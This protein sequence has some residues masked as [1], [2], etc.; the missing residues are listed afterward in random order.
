MTETEQLAAFVADFELKRLPGEVVHQ[1]KRCLLETIGCALGGAR[2]PLAATALGAAR[3]L[4]EGGCATVLGQGFRTAPDR[5]AFLNG[6]AGNALD[7]D[8]GIVRQGHYGPTVVASALAVGELVQAPGER[9]LAAVVAGYE[10][11]ARV[12]MA[13]R[14][15]PGQ[16]ALVSGYG[17]YQGFGAVAAAGLLLGLDRDRMVH[18][19]GLCGAF[20]PVPSTKGC[21][22]DRRPLSWTKDMVAWPSVSGINAALLAEAGFLGPR[23]IFEGDR[24]FFRM[25]GSDRCAPDQLVAGLGREFRILDLYFKPYPCCRWIHA[26]LEGVREILRRRGWAGTEVRAVRVGVAQ[27]VLDDLADPSPRNLVDAEFSLPYG[28]AMVLL[29]REPGPRWHDPALLTD[30]QVTAAM[31]KVAVVQDAGLE[32]L[33]VEQSIVGAAVTVTGPDGSQDRARVERTYGD[34]TQP[35]S[36]ADLDSKF[37]RLAAETLAPDAAES[38]LQAGWGLERLDRIGALTALLE[39]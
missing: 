14:A 5:A 37:R 7:Y 28:V 2:T 4:G 13:L 29:D 36:D 35:M 22:W 27:E 30:P 1:A 16:R 24:G 38:A 12:G 31:G 25:A 26:A 23:S 8:G 32:P 20:A 6:V 9:V 17:P 39:G 11:V 19:L 18:A 34:V 21:N 33:F 3:R 10:V 15:S